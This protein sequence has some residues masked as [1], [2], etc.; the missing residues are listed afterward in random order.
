MAF[1]KIIS[2]PGGNGASCSKYFY[3]D[4]P[5]ENNKNWIGVGE[6]AEVPDEDLDRHLSSGKLYQASASEAA[7]YFGSLG[8]PKTEPARRGRPPKHVDNDLAEIYGAQR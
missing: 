6:V 2:L 4:G 1:I 3:K 8:Q 5:R 7:A